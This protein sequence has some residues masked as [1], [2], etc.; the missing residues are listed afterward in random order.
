M[1]TSAVY[2]SYYDDIYQFMNTFIPE[3]NGAD[4]NDSYRLIIERT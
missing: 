4:F 2:S 1:N 3:L